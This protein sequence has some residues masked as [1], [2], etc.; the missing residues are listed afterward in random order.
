MNRADSIAID[1]GTKFVGVAIGRSLDRSCFPLGVLSMLN[2]E[3]NLMH[4]LNSRPFKYLFIGESRGNINSE[5]I[6]RRL[7]LAYSAKIVVDEFGTTISGLLDSR[8]GVHNGNDHAK[9]ALEIMKL[10]FQKLP[11]Q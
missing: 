1:I 5:H 3:C 4:L 7:G 8:S 6:L 9:A 2:P 10:G 11:P